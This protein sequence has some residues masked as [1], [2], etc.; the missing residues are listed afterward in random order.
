MEC[1]GAGDIREKEHRLLFQR[2][3]VPFLAPILQLTT[4]I[5]VQEAPTASMGTRHAGKMPIYIKTKKE[6]RKE[7]RKREKD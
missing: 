5:S 2:T 4:V 6:R 3:Q 1:Q 7:G